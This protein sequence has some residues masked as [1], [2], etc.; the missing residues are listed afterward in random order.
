MPGERRIKGNK[1]TFLLTN[2]GAKSWMLWDQTGHKGALTMRT[3]I[4]K[5]DEPDE[6]LY[7]RLAAT[8]GHQKIAKARIGIGECYAELT[9]DEQLS[10]AIESDELQVGVGNR[11]IGSRDAMIKNTIYQGEASDKPIIQED[12][13]RLCIAAQ[14]VEDD[15]AGYGGQGGLPEWWK[16]AT[17]SQNKQTQVIDD[18]NPDVRKDFT[19]LD[20]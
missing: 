20:Y 5:T 16:D 3:F 14:I 17:I 7:E 9:A 2:A 12:L 8:Y 11:F 13:Q 1:G 18:T 15:P 10:K 6:T 19:K 4:P